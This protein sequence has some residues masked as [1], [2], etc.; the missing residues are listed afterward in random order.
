MTNLSV[1]DEM[2]ST[3]PE[4]LQ[5]MTWRKRDL[6]RTMDNPSGCVSYSGFDD[7]ISMVN[8]TE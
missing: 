8:E 1:F 2:F 3:C 6:P 5:H 7:E 4:S